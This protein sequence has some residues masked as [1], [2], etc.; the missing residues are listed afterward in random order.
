MRLYHPLPPHDLLEVRPGLLRRLG[1]RRSAFA[2]I[3]EVAGA[4]KLVPHDRRRV[5]KKK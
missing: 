3:E 4:R 2:T 5:V 1:L